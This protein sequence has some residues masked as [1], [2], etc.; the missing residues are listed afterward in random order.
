[1][2]KINIFGENLPSRVIYTT[3]SYGG[4]DFQLNGNAALQIISNDSASPNINI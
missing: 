1:M 2:G 3:R 4:I